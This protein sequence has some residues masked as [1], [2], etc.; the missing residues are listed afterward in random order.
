MWFGV[1]GCG[2]VGF[3]VVEGGLMWLGKAGCGCAWFNVAE[4][5]WV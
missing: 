4:R 1:A 5:V 2:C 3:N